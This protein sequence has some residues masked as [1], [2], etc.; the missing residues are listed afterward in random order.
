MRKNDVR[1]WIHAGLD[2]LP[3]LIIPIFGLAVRSDNNFQP[4]EVTFKEEVFAQSN[5]V[6]TYQDIKVGNIYK[7]TDN[8]GPNTIPY[9]G[10]FSIDVNQSLFFKQYPQ[11]AEGEYSRIY[12]YQD[13]NGSFY[14]RLLPF[15]G[16]AEYQPINALASVFLVESVSNLNLLNDDIL[17][18]II[19]TDYQ[20]SKGLQYVTY[21]D[22]DV[23]SQ[24]LYTLYNS[25]DKYFNLNNVFNFNQIYDWL[26]VNI[27]HGTA[28]MSIYIAWNIFL[29]E[30]L[31]DL[32]FLLYALF[33]F[34]VD[35]CSNL[36]DRFHT[37]CSG[38]K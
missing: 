23:G 22:T 24:M 38:G 18:H 8:V 4:I 15:V 9:V 26:E 14:Y 11:Y 5:I 29:Y 20:F 35:F 12:L 19:Y 6:E 36:I 10:L 3:L 25:C 1:K 16:S 30:F 32:I 34:F 21:N 17:E 7:W 37:K 27:F 28:P 33:M 31:M 2:L 13:T